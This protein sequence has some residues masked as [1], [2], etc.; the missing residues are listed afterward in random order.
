M[1][2]YSL[3]NVASRPARVRQ[4]GHNAIPKLSDTR[5]FR[6]RSTRGGGLYVA[7]NGGGVRPT[8][9]VR[10]P[11]DGLAGKICGNGWRVSAK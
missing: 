3:H 9:S 11:Y 4:A 10:R 8:S 5:F 6:A 1:C 7:R 2:D